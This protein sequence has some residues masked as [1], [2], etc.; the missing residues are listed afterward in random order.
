MEGLR[1]IP[2]LLY[3]EFGK[4]GGKEKICRLNSLMKYRIRRIA[5]R[6]TKFPGS[7]GMIIGL[8]CLSETVSYFNLWERGYHFRLRPGESKQCILTVSSCYEDLIHEQ[9]VKIFFT[10]GFFKLNLQSVLVGAIV[11]RAAQLV[12]EKGSS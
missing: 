2:K 11:L 1:S 3:Q 12:N 5:K 10:N 7:A 8:V 9:V 6:N 4:Y